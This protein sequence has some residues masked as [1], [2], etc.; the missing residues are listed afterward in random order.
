[1][2]N[3]YAKKLNKYFYLLYDTYYVDIPSTLIE[4]LRKEIFDLETKQY[5]VIF[6]VRYNSYTQ[7]ELLK[8]FLLTI[9]I[10]AH[11]KS[12]SFINLYLLYKKNC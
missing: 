12:K 8:E 5:W 1:M 6:I 11:L 2:F 9:G 7:I 4:L 3:K 10:S